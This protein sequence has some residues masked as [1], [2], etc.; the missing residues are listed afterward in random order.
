MSFMQK[1]AM[2]VSRF[3]AGRNGPDNLS[4]TSLWAGVICS[5]L[6]SMIGSGLLSMIGMALYVYSVFRLLS[7]NTGKR[8]AENRAFVQKKNQIVTSVKQ[9]FMRVKNSRQYKYFRCPQCRVIIRLT[10]GCGE[11]TIRCPKC[12]HTFKQKA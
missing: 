8:A 11:K 12:S 10:R 7:R 1:L 4:I 9:F 6:A 3:M 2:V 5:I